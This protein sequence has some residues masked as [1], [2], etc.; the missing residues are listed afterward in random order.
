MCWFTNHPSQFWV[1]EDQL[2]Y[3][4]TSEFWQNPGN[5]FPGDTD[6]G[7]KI[8]ALGHFVKE[9]L[10]KKILAAGSVSIAYYTRWVQLVRAWEVNTPQTNGGKSDWSSLTFCRKLKNISHLTS[11]LSEEKHFSIYSVKEREKERLPKWQF[12]WQLLSQLMHTF[13]FSQYTWFSLSFLCFTKGQSFVYM[14]KLNHCWQ[15]GEAKGYFL[16]LHL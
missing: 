1:I 12:F 13:C 14:A 8:F 15:T 9:R 6:N 10:K 4:S 3:S 7:Q 2:I 16:C 11:L 5:F